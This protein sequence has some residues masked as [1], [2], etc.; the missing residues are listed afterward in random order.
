MTALLNNHKTLQ[1]G[2]IVRILYPLYVAGEIG[3]ILSKEVVEQEEN[4]DY[5]LVKIRGEKI[6]L[7]LLPDEFQILKMREV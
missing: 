5:W 6:V 2:M 7:A 4:S 3:K 1:P